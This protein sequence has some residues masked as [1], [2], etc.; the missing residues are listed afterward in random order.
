[1]ELC[2]KSSS[3]WALPILV[4]FFVVLLSNNG[5]LASHKVFIHLQDT[6]AINIKTVGR[7]G[8]HFQPPKHWINGTYS[9]YVGSVLYIMYY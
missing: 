2:N 9:T 1:M 5:V 8:Y 7:T 6:S 3:R 4:C